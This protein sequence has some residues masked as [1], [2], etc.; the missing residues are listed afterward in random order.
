MKQVKLKH[1]GKFI[2]PHGV[3]GNLLL[4]I[5]NNVSLDLLDKTI[6]EKEWIFVDMDGIPVPFCI[7]ENGLRP[8]GDNAF[9]IKLD[10][11]DANEA[12]NMCP[13]NVFVNIF[14]IENEIKPTEDYN[15][16]VNFVI[17][18]EKSG[19]IGKVEYFLDIKENPLIA[20]N[21]NEKEILLPLQSE[22]VLNIDFDQ[23]EI[24]TNFPENYLDSLS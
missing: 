18:D 21:Y 11:I 2:K 1:I 23:Q 10:N 3:H 20:A 4:T 8:S 12:K 19:V 13:T 14:Y 5:D 16:I 6:I 17:I 22:Y 9:L 24:H 15:S 7:S